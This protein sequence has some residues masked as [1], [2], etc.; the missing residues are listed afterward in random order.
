M[1]A[2]LIASTTLLLL[3]AP[4]LGL[5]VIFG[6]SADASDA[7]ALCATSG[8]VAGLSAE[9]A[10]NARTIVSVT[11]QVVTPA[12]QGSVGPASVIA[13]ITA[14]QESR[15]RDL[16]NPNV[17]GS[18]QQPGASGTGT[19]HDSIGLFQQRTSWGTVAQRMDP[20]WATKA[21]LGRL[22]AVP[23]WQAMPPSVAAQAVQISATPDAYAQWISDAQAWTDEIDN[24]SSAQ[25]CG[26]ETIA[27]S[28]STSLPA[29]FTLPAGTSPAAARAV[30]F[31]LAQLGKPYVF[32]AA[33]PN[34]YDCSGLTMVAW[35]TG[36]ITLPH[37]ASAQAQLG[38][39]VGGLSLLR[40]GDLIF[41][42][43]SDGT[44]QSPGHVGMFVGAGLVIEAPETGVPI[45]LVP[46]G[47]FGPVA[48]V[49]HYA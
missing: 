11:Q 42:P 41:I 1:R 6:G 47:A 39:P 28:G 36:G 35:A 27:G 4:L 32:D 13:L 30:S 33:G 37:L 48:A 7:T 5:T 44:M 40:P 19:D 46:V 10:A 31:A 2:A 14:Y 24:G 15:L 16:S 29:G 43:G 38:S 34:A 23:G 17:P 12:D 18:A 3:A 25:A 49:R 20:V 21:F 22:L 45:K 26:A 9:Q 8:P